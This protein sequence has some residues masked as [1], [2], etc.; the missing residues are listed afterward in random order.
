MKAQTPKELIDTYNEGCGFD[1]NPNN[2]IKMLT[3][4]IDDIFV[5]NQKSSTKSFLYDVTNGEAMGNNSATDERG[6]VI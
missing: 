1:Y 5:V 6:N 4:L 2:I 3:E